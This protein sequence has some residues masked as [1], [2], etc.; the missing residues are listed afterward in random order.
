VRWERDARN[1]A[2][3]EVIE[4]YGPTPG[5]RKTYAIQRFLEKRGVTPNG[6]TMTFGTM[7]PLSDFRRHLRSFTVEGERESVT[8]SGGSP[9]YKMELVGKDAKIAHHAADALPGVRMRHGRKMVVSFDDV[10]A[11]HGFLVSLAHHYEDGKE[12]AGDLA[13]AVMQTLGYEW[14]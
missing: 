1:P 2:A 12:E 6:T 7:P 11:L 14:V 10:A 5:D 9:V 13:S 8:D 4:G 3:W